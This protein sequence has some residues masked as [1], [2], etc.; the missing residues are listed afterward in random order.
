MLNDIFARRYESVELRDSFQERDR[1]L[2]IQAF[3]I[4]AEDLRPYYVD[5]KKSED[6]EKFWKA[7]HNQVARE[8]GVK[9]L[10]QRYYS[11]TT[12]WAG[13][14]STQSGAFDW[15]RVCETWLV[16][17]PTLDPDAHIKERLSLI[18]LGFRLRANGL[19]SMR[20]AY[21][22]MIAKP[23][24]SA[25]APPPSILTGS[26][27]ARRSDSGDWFHQKQE[28]DETQ[29]RRCVDELNERFRQARY[30]LDYHNGF[31]QIAEGDLVQREV[32]DPFWR[33]VADP[34]WENVDIDMKEALDLRDT[35]GRD[36]A[37]YAAKSLESTIKI[38]SS[39]KGWTQGRENGAHNYIDNLAS[40]KNSYLTQ[41]EAEILKAFF[42]KVRNPFGHGPGD[43]PM[44]SLS[45]EQTDWAIE[46]SMSWIKSLIRRF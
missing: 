4:L 40:K 2:L 39:Q 29:F 31:I 16:A 14:E 17:M 8:L 44:P 32:E 43:A 42:S 23:E 6:G 45:T 1:R 12:M 3:Q 25:P 13:K 5:G 19:K 24:P 20:D 38:I 26:Q 9:E 35:G 36:P 15:V 10:S 22:R 34:L 21:E 28:R 27:L 18:E 37:W 33:I 7:L 46:F 11:Y 41:W 30:P